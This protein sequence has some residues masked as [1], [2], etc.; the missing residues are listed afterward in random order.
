GRLALYREPAAG[1]GRRVDSGVSEGDA[2]SPF[3]DP[4]LAKLIAWGETREEARLR[5][6]AVRDGTCVAGVKSNLP[7]LR[8]VLAHPAFASAALDTDFI[9]RHQAQLL[10]AA[11]P[12]GEDFWALAAD[13][14]LQS[15]PARASDQDPH[16]PWAQRSGW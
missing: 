8:R 6:L 1:P 15:E 2:V 12:L 4:L 5:L 7:F 10:P 16:S 9:P 3:Y 11:E 13:A 14:W